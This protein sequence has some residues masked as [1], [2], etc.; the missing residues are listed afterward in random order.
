MI[1]FNIFESTGVPGE[2]L[3]GPMGLG[4]P[5]V[6]GFG[7]P[8]PHGDLWSRPPA[9]Q[10]TTVNFYIDFFKMLKSFGFNK[11]YVRE[12]LVEYVISCLLSSACC[13]YGLS[14]QEAPQRVLW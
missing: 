2:G 4:G 14:H 6:P 5:E 1:N 3:R 13:E 12:G 11:I 7:G 9:P 10:K 8:G